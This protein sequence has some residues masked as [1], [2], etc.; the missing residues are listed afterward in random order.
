MF[1]ITLPA[2]FSASTAQSKRWHDSTFGEGLKKQSHGKI[3]PMGR[4]Y[5]PPFSGNSFPSIF[6]K[7]LFAMSKG[8]GGRGT[9]FL[10]RK[11]MLKIGPK[12]VVLQERKTQF[13]AKKFLISIR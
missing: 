5:C 4:G 13:S 1:R 7:L 10:L 9:P 11:N 2:A 3:P 6:G 8:E 12:T